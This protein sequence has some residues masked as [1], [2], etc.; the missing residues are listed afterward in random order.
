MHLRHI[1]LWEFRQGNTAATAIDKMCKICAP[2]TVSV[3]QGQRCQILESTAP[4]MNQKFD[5]ENYTLTINLCKQLRS[6]EHIKT[7]VETLGQ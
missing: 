1:L 5:D 4:K 2:G 6:I 3:S 7:V